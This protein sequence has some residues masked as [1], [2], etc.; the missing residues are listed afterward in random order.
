MSWSTVYIKGKVGFEREVTHQLEKSGFSFLRGTEEN[1][2]S[3][4]WIDNLAKLREFKM[5]I[6]SKTIF[7]YRLRFFSSLEEAEQKSVFTSDEKRKIK[8]MQEWDRLRQSA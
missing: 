6:G 5:A 1:G 8:K 7:K 3:L 4:F 2:F